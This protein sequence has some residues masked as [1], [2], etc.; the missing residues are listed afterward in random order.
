[1][2][3]MPLQLKIGIFRTLTIVLGLFGLAAALHAQANNRVS[4]L[5]TDPTGAVIVGATVTAQDNGTNVVTTATSNERGYYLLQLPIGV[6]DIKA[7]STG[8]RP[9]LREKVQVSVGAD[10]GIHFELSL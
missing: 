10:V 6:Y 8:F 1:M 5:V 2:S 4:G 3:L 9:S 7:T